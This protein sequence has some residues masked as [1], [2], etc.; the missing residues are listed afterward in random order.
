MARNYSK[1]RGGF[2]TRYPRR[3]TRRRR[4]SGRW[5]FFWG[6][7][8]ILAA[9]FFQWLQAGER[10]SPEPPAQPPARTSTQPPAKLPVDLAQADSFIG[11]VTRVADGDSLRVALAGSGQEIRVRLYGLDAPEL[12]QPHG[13]ESREF[14]AK[15]LTD[16][17][18]RVEKQGVDRYGRVVAQVFD[19]GLSV[20]LTLVASGQAWVYD[21]FCQEPVC[22]Q[23]KTAETQARQ[24]KL[25][26]WGQGQPQ[27][28]WQ[29]RRA[30][31]D[32]SK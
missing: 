4:P 9:A 3:L 2:G 20:N 29:W 26:L 24:K 30:Q 12:A 11:R 17:E 28:P 10:P 5:K 31:R 14:L 32:R 21:Q 7:A 23:M 19:S 13:R 18:V 15:L 16:R 8:L 1:R 6:L 25:G 22:A 27:P